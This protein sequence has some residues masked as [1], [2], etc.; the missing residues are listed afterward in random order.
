MNKIIFL[1]LF[2]LVIITVSAQTDSSVNK[3]DSF[4]MHQKGLLGKLAR[5]LMSDKPASPSTPVRKD[6][7]FSRYRGK[8]IRNIVIRRLDFGTPITDT[9]RKFETGLT[10]LANDLHR[11]TREA[12]VRKNL[13]FKKGEQLIPYLIADNE[14]YLRDLPYLHDADIR[15]VYVNQDSV[16][17][18]V[19]TKD[20]LSLGGSI[21]MHNTTKLSIT[22]SEANI[23]GSGQ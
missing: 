22:V 13:F 19:L 21:R 6:L 10:R 20:V 15:V 14:R 2:C 12:V 8:Y 9:A 11:K 3:V 16:D 7:L 5:N 4:L 18:I 1:V 17:I 23:A